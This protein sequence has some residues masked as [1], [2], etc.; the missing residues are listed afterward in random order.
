MTVMQPTDFADGRLK[1]GRD[2]AVGRIIFNNPDRMNAMALAMWD[3]LKEA[4]TLFEH[5]DTIRVVVLSG[6]GEKA[7]VS[8]AD[9]SEFDQL[10]ST[11]AGVED[12]NARS[13]AADAALYNFSKP[14]I[15]EI[16]GFCVGGGMGLAVGCDLRICTDD[17]RIGI[18]AGKLGLGYGYD[19]VRKLVHLLGPAVTAEILYTAKL[20]TAE[21]A[22]LKGMVSQIVPRADLRS[23]VDDL[24]H[25]I[26]A[27]APLT[28]EAA[29]AAIRTISVPE[30]GVSREGVNALTAA[31]FASEDYAE[32]RAAFAQKRKPEFKRR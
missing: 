8:G 4:L 20:F 32:G 2:G 26:A 13:E 25:R 27:N 30:N 23:A 28:V 19:G 24:A 29:K 21:E 22:L 5:D 10:R 17:T 11:P 31:C 6:A 18:T 3:G 16:K 12:Y 14:T 15:A 1:A 9:I 7:F